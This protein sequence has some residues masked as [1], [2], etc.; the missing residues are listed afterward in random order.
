MSINYKKLA[1]LIEQEVNRITNL[2]TQQKERLIKLSNKL[3]T[4]ESSIDSVS[5]QKMVEDIMMEISL[6]IPDFQSVGKN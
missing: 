6:A 2:S 1:G 3:Y 4:L 5:S